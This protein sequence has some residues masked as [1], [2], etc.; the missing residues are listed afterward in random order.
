MRRA[1]EDERERQWAMT[2]Y[3]FVVALMLAGVVVAVLTECYSQ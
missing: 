3:L 1:P 2:H